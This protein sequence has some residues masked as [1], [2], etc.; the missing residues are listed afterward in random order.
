MIDPVFSDHFSSDVFSAAITQNAQQW[1]I[2]LFDGNVK[3]YSQGNSNPQEIHPCIGSTRAL[4]F[5]PNDFSLVVGDQHGSIHI[6][7]STTLQE[8]FTQKSGHNTSIETIKYLSENI[9]VSGDTDGTVKVWDIRSSKCLQRF[10][11]VQDYVA[12]IAPV[13]GQQ[14]IVATGDGQGHLY[15]I[16]RQKRLQYYQQED[17]DFTSCC[18]DPFCRIAVFSSDRPKVYS[19]RVP[20]FDFVSGCATLSKKP[21]I[22]VRSLGNIN[23]RITVVHDDGVVLISD[24]Y[25]NKQIYSFKSD[26]N[27]LRGAALSGTRLITWN[28]NKE[29][30]IWDLTNF[31][32]CAPITGKA[33]SSKSNRKNRKNII[34]HKKHD[35]FFDDL[36]GNDEE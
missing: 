25:P 20:S 7:D 24:I 35:P 1:A 27:P 26:N 17:D 31:K 36:R 10:K 18:Y 34:I 32:T 30:K 9:L 16:S 5:N 3:L 4:E 19:V 14:F 15:H 29:A 6:F 33:N 12:D 21:I 28:N 22:M 8:T 11:P 2:G 23:C 13:D